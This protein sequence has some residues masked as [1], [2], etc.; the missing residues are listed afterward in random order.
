MRAIRGSG[1]VAS[2]TSAGVVLVLSFLVLLL[3]PGAGGATGGSVVDIDYVE[4]PGGVEGVYITHDDGV[5]DGRDGL[6]H[7]GDRPALATGESVIALSV[8][9]DADGYWL[10]TD[11]GS[12]FEYGAAGFH[13]DAS[14]LSLDQP[15]VSA[16]AMPDGLGY[17]MVAEDGGIF[18]FGSA[19]FPG[20]VP[21]ILPGVELDAPVIG[22]VPSPTGDGYLL[23][24][25][26][27][28]IFTFGD[29][30]FYGSVPGVLPG[31]ALDAEVVAVIAQQSGYLMVAADGGIF[32]FGTAKFLGSIGG[33]GATGIV[34]VAAKP[35]SSGYVMVDSVG[36]LSP[37]GTAESLG[38]FTTG[39]LAG[40][41]STSEE[42]DSTTP[43]PTVTTPT[44]T[45]EEPTTATTKPTSDEVGWCY[46]KSDRHTLV[47]QNRI[48]RQL[49]LDLEPAPF[50]HL[51]TTGAK[52][53]AP[54][55]AEVGWCVEH[56]SE[57]VPIR[58]Y[59][60]A[61]GSPLTQAECTAQHG[62]DAAWGEGAIATTYCSWRDDSPGAV[63][64]HH[65]CNPESYK[66]WSW[67]DFGT[68]PACYY[69]EWIKGDCV[70]WDCDPVQ[71][72]YQ[73][74]C[75]APPLHQNH[76]QG[77]LGWCV[78]GR[79][80]SLEY[81]V[82]ERNCYGLFGPFTSGWGTGP[83]PQEVLEETGNA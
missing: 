59:G 19:E 61:P 71:W 64:P 48:T 56:N 83:V 70:E 32:T 30:V 17:Y 22:I 62:S 43:T 47:R 31:V 55:S 51:W 10:F 14:L 33:T 2:V 69:M 25:A 21:Q 76:D 77:P 44:A 36:S 66:N 12:V 42:T 7:F 78:G 18:G 67:G 80:S 52:P 75:D 72:Y 1:W 45:T 6:P 81:A 38:S 11:L 60:L 49:C 16:I 27:G 46:L 8:R 65:L 74:A 3:A 5:V 50:T 15:M 40:T 57:G 28:G 26:D 29:A 73:D 39:T 9:P 63:I 41:T 4:T 34:A 82:T 13:G 58:T 53:T 23:V 68:T 35:D 79:S 20:S 37:F 54:T 24:A